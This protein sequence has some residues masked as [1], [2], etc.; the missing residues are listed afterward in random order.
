MSREQGEAGSTA[1]IAGLRVPPKKHL[2]CG[3]KRVHPSAPSP[4]Q[5]ASRSAVNKDENMGVLG[6]LSSVVA[7]PLC[8]SFSSA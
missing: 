8:N 6:I 1:N 2:L 5:A 3:S 4:A 7:A